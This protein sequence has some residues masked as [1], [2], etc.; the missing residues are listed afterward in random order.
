MGDQSYE[1]VFTTIVLA[2]GFDHISN[3]KFLRAVDTCVGRSRDEVFSMM[4]R[5]FS[6]GVGGALVMRL[7]FRSM[8]PISTVHRHLGQR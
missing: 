2:I 1:T 4:D 7:Q 6:V 3:G 8:L 5:L